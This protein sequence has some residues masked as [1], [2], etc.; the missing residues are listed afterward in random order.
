MAGHG[1]RRG[2][3]A[4]WRWHRGHGYLAAGGP[5]Q[6]GRR[7][8]GG[9]RPAAALPAAMAGH[10]LHDVPS[11]AQAAR[12]AHAPALTIRAAYR[13]GT[14]QVLAAHPVAARCCADDNIESRFL[15]RP[16]GSGDRRGQWAGSGL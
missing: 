5:D 15:R 14:Q 13:H 2:R 3:I 7:A 1:R 9:H 4:D 6:G 11:S 12:T 16:G 10:C 8:V